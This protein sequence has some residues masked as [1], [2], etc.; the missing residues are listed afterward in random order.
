MAKNDAAPAWAPTH[1]PEA[2]EITLHCTEGGSDKVYRVSIDGGGQGPWSV[3]YANG[4]RG[5]TLATGTKT[6]APV[7]WAAAR[8]ICVK[9]VS[10]KTAKGYNPIAGTRVDGVEAGISLVVRAEDSGARPQLLNP[11]DEAR[12]QELLDDDSYAAQEKFDGERR[13]AER[14]ADASRGVNR[15][16]QIVALT[17]PIENALAAFAQ[18][19]LFDGEQIGDVLHVFDLL[20]RDGVDL[21]AKTMLERSA[22]LEEEFK[23]A[24]S[25]GAEGSVRVVDTAIGTEAKR[26]LWNR[27][28]AAGGEG[29]VFK[30]IDAPYEPGRP[31]S[32]GTQLKFKF[33]ETLSAIV[34]IVNASRSVSLRL[35]EKDG[36]FLEVGNVTVPANQPVPR[37]GEIVEVR[38][39]YAY[40]GGS[41]YQPVLLGTRTDVG[42]EDCSASQRK[43]KPAA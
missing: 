30:K 28:K 41:L 3:N 23:R 35:V 11:I 31:N 10:E 13:M 15:K 29:V 19:A 1:E 27:V 43:F 40:D 33:H 5:G 4:R 9:L 26:A 24:G 37:P 36:N 7:D 2:Y 16:G 34:G 17:R 8:K 20:E 6:Q 14:R 32:G 22:L 25:S 12:A 21:R 38:Y 39:L 18:N 42:A